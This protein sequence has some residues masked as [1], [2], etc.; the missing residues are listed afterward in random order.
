MDGATL[1]ASAVMQPAGAAAL[2]FAQVILAAQAA[3]AVE[4]DGAGAIVLD[5]AALAANA[6]MQ[7]DGV[8][9]IALGTAGDTPGPALVTNGAFD[10]DSDWTL[11]ANWTIAGGTLNAGD[12]GTGTYQSIGAVAGRTYRVAFTVSNTTQSTVQC[13]LGGTEVVAAATDGNYEVDVVA[14]GAND[15]LQFNAASGGGGWNGSIDDVSVRQL[16]PVAVTLAALGAEAIA[17][18]GALVLDGATLAASAFM[19]PDGAAALTFEQVTLAG[20]GEAALGGVVILDAVALAGAAGLEFEGS[21][22]IVLDGVTL[23]ALVS[24]SEGAA[25]T[26]ALILDGVTLAALGTISAAFIRT[27]RRGLTQSGLSRSNVQSGLRRRNLQ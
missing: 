17:G 22:V 4:V 10:T 13:T 1:A 11:G 26:A 9:A 6:I 12:G 25:G 20:L 5:P 8:G 18:N 23:A 2:T 7:P 19:H 3:T 15:R 14:G 24:T 16:L 21:A 27:S